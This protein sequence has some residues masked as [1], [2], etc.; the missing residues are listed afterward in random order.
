M[1]RSI[2]RES[3]TPDKGYIDSRAAAIAAIN[4]MSAELD[5]RLDAAADGMNDV[6]ALLADIPVRS[7][8]ITLTCLSDGTVGIYYSSGEKLPRIG[9]S[10]KRLSPAGKLLL[11]RLGIIAH[12][13]DTVQSVDSIETA[14]IGNAKNTRVYFRC[15]D[16]LRKAEYDMEHVDECGD[17]IRSLDTMIKDLLQMIHRSKER[18]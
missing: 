17:D 12:R 2:S 14:G 18:I 13:C 5:A 15:R 4:R 8:F 10:G 16:G 3:S 1:R 11:S 6:I 7:R 9:R